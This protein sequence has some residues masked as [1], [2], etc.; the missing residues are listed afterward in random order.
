MVSW[1][2]ST[3]QGW[4]SAPLSSP[5]ELL[6]VASLTHG[7]REALRAHSSGWSGGDLVDRVARD[8]Q[9]GL[10]LLHRQVRVAPLLQMG[11]EQSAEP[12]EPPTPTQTEP[13]LTFVE[14]TLTD[15]AGEPLSDERFELTLPDGATRTG[16]TDA[17]GW[18]RVN[19]VSTPGQCELRLVDVDETYWELEGKG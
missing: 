10:L 4:E 18:A 11:L 9:S 8:L 1:W 12:T 15:L 2:E 5:T 14:L 19:G 3:G 7:G 16:A 6:R 13:T 17:R